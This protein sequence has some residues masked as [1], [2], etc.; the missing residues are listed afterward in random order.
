M[1]YPHITKAAL[2]NGL[3]LSALA[4]AC[5]ATPASAQN[6]GPQTAPA[7]SVE[8]VV[9]TGARAENANIVDEKR[10]SDGVADFFSA[11]ES[12]QLPDLNIAETLRR[13]PGVTSIFDEDRGRFVTV[14][15]LSASL[16]YITIEGI[17]IATTDDFAGTGRKVNLEVIPS[18]AVGLL[19][20]RKTFTPEVDGGA[21]GGYVNLHT[22]SAFDTRKRFLLIEGGVN[23]QTY[24][25]VP[26]DNSYKGPLKSPWG[27]QF[28]ITLADRFG[29][30]EQF[31]VVLSGHFKQDS[32]DESK[33][34]QA[35]EQYFDS[36]GKVV[37]PIL[38]GGQVNPAWNGFVAPA[39]VRSYDYTNR[40]RDY[41]G[42]AKFE[43]RSG[44]LYAS[45]TG[46]Y[47]A[48][49]QQETR[50]TVQ[51]HSLATITSQTA[52][53]GALRV[54]DARIGWNR[55]NLDRENYGVILKGSAERG[56]HQARLT[57]G[58]TYNNFNDWQPLIDYRGVPT[59]TADR[60]I[61]YSVVTTDP[62]R[63]SFTLTNPQAFLNPAIY[64]LRGYT[65]QTRFASENV[66]DGRFDYGFNNQRGDQ[67]LGVGAGAEYRRIDRVRD[68]T[69]IE[70]VPDRSLMTPYALQ[71][72]FQPCWLNYPLLWINA[73][74]FLDNKAHTLP[75]NAANT[76]TRSTQD[77]F[78]YVEDS[79]AVYAFLTHAGARHKFIGGVRYENVDTLAI[80]PGENLSA[81]FLRRK[82][83][84][85]KVL[86]SATFAYDLSDSLRLKLGASRSL[87]RPDPGD[88]AQRQRRDDAN[89][90]ISRGNP[91]LKPRTA[92]NL[93]LALEYYFPGRNGLFSV[94]VFSKDIKDEIF[95][96]KATEV[97][98]GSN[99]VVT[100]P[101][102]AEGSKVRGIEAGLIYNRFDFLPK[103]FDGLGLNANVT[104]VDGQ[105]AYLNAAGQRTVLH[106]LVDQSRWF[107]NAALFYGFSD[108]AEVRLSYNY[109][110]KYQDAITDEPETT[111][112][113]ASFNT[114]DVSASYA[115]NDHM[116]LKFKARNILNNDRTRIRGIGLSDL[117]EETEYGNTYYL[118]VQYKF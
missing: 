72:D 70:Y 35:S 53:S 48:E 39:E 9:V 28:D 23:R 95:V 109:W 89:F 8:E 62:A 47:Y 26:G 80:A 100:Q 42:L 4:I 52:T 96:Q 78:R 108:K 110:G 18:S 106:R 6:A 55:N 85:D 111:Q 27:G 41:G 93:D 88:V 37:D 57:A 75:V 51:L 79:T 13:I 36:A 3:A 29:R 1:K 94:A 34:I 61:S 24:K 98:D 105:I 74:A 104:Y 45:A 112:G 81:A 103:P 7:T 101:R 49:G 92:T 99:Y 5:A 91:D 17:G 65:E 86:P 16:N 68:N 60:G 44:G 97:I 116:K 50:N 20:V 69:L 117:Y 64:Q 77:D 33:N 32:R 63:N 102:N 15:G 113:W 90:T 54:G 67:G 12:G 73:Q 115:V 114:V 46:F 83:N 25:D 58:W 76:L 56:R 22:R 82:G 43:F 84:Y 31:G 87:G 14:R 38:A 40:V 21:I 107:G 66:Y 11:D 2:A 10:K 118:T 71:T 59:A 30:D 19:E